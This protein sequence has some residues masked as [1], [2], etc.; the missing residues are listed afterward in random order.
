MYVGLKIDGAVES[1]QHFVL[2]EM[3]L[4]SSR[5]QMQK[6]NFELSI[7]CKEVVAV[8]EGHYLKLVKES[9]DD[10][11]QCGGPQDE[12]GLANYPDLVEVL[13]KSELLNLVVG[14][15]LF[16]ELVVNYCNALEEHKFWYDAVT[17][18]TLKHDLVFIYGVCYS[19]NC[20]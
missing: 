6:H 20:A 16:N 13:K 19:R 9:F 12:L 8:L 3:S 7:P 11:N 14:G 17:E 15:Y 18:C 5:S 1:I 10:D 4:S 2:P